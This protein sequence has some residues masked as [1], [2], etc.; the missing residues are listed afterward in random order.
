MR[1]LVVVQLTIPSISERSSPFSTLVSL[2]HT[3]THLPTR[4]QAICWIQFWS[5]IAWFPF[6]F[7]SST[8]V[9]ET[10]F[11]YDQPLSPRGNSLKLTRADEPATSNSRSNDTLGDIG[12]LGSHA[13]V[14]FSIVT[15]L[16]SA[17]L[18]L[19]VSSP[20]QNLSPMSAETSPDE[21]PYTPRPPLFLAK[22]LSFF[23]ENTM[24]GSWKPELS[25]VWL[26]S[27]LLLASILV[28][29]PWIHSFRAATAVVALCGIP[30]A[31][32]CWAPFTFMGVEINRLAEGGPDN[33]STTRSNGF[34]R[35]ISPS[36]EEDNDLEMSPIG[37]PDHIRP[38]PPS[39]VSS[40]QSHGRNV[41]DGV[42]RLL[43]VDE[44]DEPP[45][46]GEL[47]GVYLGVLNVY[48]VLPQF[49]GTF[50]AWVVFSIL[51]PGK[52]MDE[53]SGSS[54]SKSDH[55]SWLE[56]KGDKPNAISVCLFIGAICATFA[57]EAT[58]RFRLK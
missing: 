47:A 30:W 54:E 34:Y 32:A 19:L 28:W 8:W 24:R 46:T 35:P 56:L 15:F 25:I 21:R 43:H 31:I 11:R 3:T 51:E 33:L 10:Y 7:Y 50:I 1:V 41:S 2:I 52:N 29:A 45:P 53:D 57:A 18:P 13:L 23:S 58:R 4:I 14:I 26:L 20:N 17:G 37:L 12:R 22:L 42:L 44:Q 6:L 38:R 9:G 48:T 36:A 40:R 5:W 27:H 16:G 55:T 39:R 49:V